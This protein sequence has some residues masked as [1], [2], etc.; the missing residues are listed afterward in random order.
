MIDLRPVGDEA[1]EY[2]GLLLILGDKQ[3][4]QRFCKKL[5]S[6]PGEPH[7]DAAAYIMARS[8][9]MGPTDAVEPALIVEW[10]T[11]GLKW[12]HRPWTLH[13]LGLAYYRAGQYDAA[14]ENIRK[15]NGT[16]WGGKTDKGES[17]NQ[18]LLAMIQQRLG[19]TAEARRCFEQAQ[20]MIK[21]V[22]PETANGPTRIDLPDWIEL[23]VLLREAESLLNLNE[24]A[25]RTPKLTEFDKNATKETPA[26][27]GNETPPFKKTESATDP[28]TPSPAADKSGK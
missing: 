24:A 14:I 20:P 4:Y 16:G 7:N 2:A 28:R 27:A 21:L 13:V 17:I 6:R 5:V 10:A 9:A 15:S 26:V 19:H 1:F 11:R 12:E 25:K 8:C 23:N 22:W 18:L 3:A